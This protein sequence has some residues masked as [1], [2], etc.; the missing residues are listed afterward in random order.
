MHRDV[1]PENM[2]IGVGSRSNVVYLLD[3]GL[4]KC[5]KDKDT[6]AHLQYLDNKPFV[7]TARF[8]SI[9]AHLGIELSRRDDLEGLGYVLVFMLRGNLPWQSLKKNK[10]GSDKYENI[11]QS[12]LNTT[13]E[14]L[15]QGLPCI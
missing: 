8:A 6:G 7:G 10:E 2:A 15:C 14:Q 5:Y 13:I 3:F 9:N 11:L 12:K 4:S 1:K